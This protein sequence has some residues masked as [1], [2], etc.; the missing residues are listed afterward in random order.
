MARPCSK[1]AKQRLYVLTSVFTS[2]RKGF[3]VPTSN[4]C[5]SVVT[6]DLNTHDII[7]IVSETACKYDRFQFHKNL[8]PGIFNGQST[9]RKWF[10]VQ[11][12]TKHRPC[13]LII[14]NHN[15]SQ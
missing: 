2:D 10:T 4:S 5:R 8:D 6:S 14:G 15:G 13:V 9:F 11:R 12:K 1:H 7:D 3:I